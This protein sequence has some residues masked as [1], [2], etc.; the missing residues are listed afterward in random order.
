[1]LDSP[2]TLSAM[3]P[4]MSAGMPMPAQ[5]RPLG[6]GL[7]VLLG[8]IAGLTIFCG[9]PIARVRRFSANTVALLNAAAIGILVYLVIEIAQNATVPINAGI[10]IWHAGS[11]PFPVL[12]IGCFVGGL[13][14]GLVGLG[15]VATTLTRRA[16]KEADNPLV[17]AAVI[18]IGIGAHNFAEGLAIGASAASGATAI[19]IGL[20][21]GF[22]LHNATE[23]FGVAAPLV[24]KYVPSWS[25]ILL[26]G[27]IAGGPT[28]AGTVVGYTFNS[29]PLSV[30][31]LGSA[32]GALVFVI[33]ELWTVLKRT[34]LSV[35]ATT[36]MTA[37]FLLAFATEIFLDVQG[38]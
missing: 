31:F 12:L 2:N 5:R 21:V 29:T 27:I 23:G 35:A 37:G 16:A 7:T 4:A 3:G 8:A 26:A 17:L 6:F 28:F 14:L 9:L 18:A 13:L 10:S 20:I 25:Q 22:G 33:G 30:L 32:V 34:G 36:T 11:G 19:A 24:G 15:S 38:G 1:M